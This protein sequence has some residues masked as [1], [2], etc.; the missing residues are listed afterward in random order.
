MEDRDHRSSIL[1]HQR[2]MPKVSHAG[3]NHR[4]AML[5]GGG[6]D[7]VV[8]DRAAGLD[9]RFGAGIG[10]FVRDRRGKDRKR[11]KPPPSL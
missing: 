8:F 6:D 4:D 1:D 10:G 9:D 3:E 7:F 2:L 5:V 11:R